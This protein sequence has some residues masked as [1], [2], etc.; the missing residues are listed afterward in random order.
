MRGPTR[1]LEDKP[2]C[3]SIHLGGRYI[4]LSRLA[5]EGDFNH[6]YLSYIFSGQ[7]TPSAKYFKRIADL[8][9]MNMNDLMEAIEDRAKDR[10]AKLFTI[11][12]D[13]TPPAPTNT[14]A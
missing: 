7:R 2:T 11:D 3:Q 8:L 10:R 1:C 12:P 5:E 4:S 9:G 6:S 13:P 14:P